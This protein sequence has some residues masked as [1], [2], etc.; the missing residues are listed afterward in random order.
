MNNKTWYIIYV[1][2]FFSILVPTTLYLFSGDDSRSSKPQISVVVM[3]TT[4]SGHIFPTQQGNPGTME[5]FDKLM[6]SLKAG[7]LDFNQLKDSMEKCF[8]MNFNDD[9]NSTDSFPNPQD[10]NK[11]RFIVT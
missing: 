6:D 10:E 7:N 1:I 3:K 8:A 11:P 4:D 2:L 9:G 5:C